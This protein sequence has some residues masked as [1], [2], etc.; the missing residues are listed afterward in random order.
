MNK[1]TKVLSVF[2]LAGAIGT[3]IA[4]AAGCA[5]NHTYG[6][7]L[8][9]KDAN[10]H[11]YHATCGHD[12]WK[13]LE[14]HKD[15]TGDNKCDDCGYELNETP[16][17][18][19]Q[20]IIAKEV[21]GLVV[22]GITAETVVLN[23]ESKTS[24]TIDKSAIKVY[25]AK[26]GEK[27]DEVPDAYLDI[28]LT[29]PAGAAVTEWAN[30]KDDGVYKVNI[31]I[32]NAKMEEG[33][34]AT[35]ADLT[36]A[37]SITIDNAIVPNS[38]TLKSGTT[39][40]VQSVVDSI[41]STWTFEVERKNGDKVAVT[42]TP[43]I[44][45]DTSVVGE[46]KEATVEV[47]VNGV[48]CTGTVLYTITEN[49]EMRV[50][51]YAYNFGF[52]EHVGAYDE[53][54]YLV[55]SK[56]DH[57][58]TYVMI[59]G[60][61]TETGAAAGVAMEANKPRE[62]TD[63]EKYFLNRLTFG[64]GTFT[65]SG[66]VDSNV[67]KKKYLVIKA[68]SAGKLT[69]Y[70]SRNS[71]ADTRGIALWSEEQWNGNINIG[72]SASAA[73]GP[74]D[75][76]GNG[77]S[78]IP[79]ASASNKNTTGKETDPELATFTIPE[80]GVYYL[81]TATNQAAYLYYIQIDNEYN[82]S[83]VENV[84]VEDGEKVVASLKKSHTDDAEGN[85]YVQEFNLG[86]TFSVNSGYS[87]KATTAAKN[88]AKL[89]PDEIIEYSNLTFKIGTTTVVPGTTVL[90]SELIPQTGVVKVTV[91]Y[92][93]ASLQYD[94]KVNS[95]LGVDSITATIN[96]ELNKVVSSADA[97]VLV[98]KSDIIVTAN[99]TNSNVDIEYTAT[100]G[101]GTEITADGVQIGVGD[102]TVTVNATV[103]DKTTS[104]LTKTFT[105]T[106]ALKIVADG[107]GGAWLYQDQ[108]D[109]IGEDNADIA[110]DAVIEDNGSFK[111]EA[112]VAAKSGYN[113]STSDFESKITDSSN[114]PVASDTASGEALTF[115]NA[116][117]FNT[118]AGSGTD[119]IKVTAK[120]AITVYVYLNASDDKHGSN[121]AGT[122][123]YYSVNG[124]P[125]QESEQITSDARKNVMVVKVTLQ[126][127]DVLIISAK[128]GTSST[129]PRIWFY[130]IEAV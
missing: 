59:P 113:M 9:A 101:E 110:K 3:G 99:G 84:A 65:S 76:A 119:Y 78:H 15:T 86:D 25:F 35:V 115:T 17:V 124:T 28:K 103:T 82:D 95:A 75:Y 88:T 69:I 118:K 114:K 70:W 61:K 83:T 41:S 102:W 129:D 130:G 90:N 81:T 120:K 105:A 24:H 22:E 98:K 97:T 31:K 112:L 94:I 46:D 43:K 64:G 10:Q 21:D 39:T 71:S 104:S 91:E 77:S 42:G 106:V 26:N 23:K 53:D 123:A 121:R 60:S 5:H 18:G 20:L 85:P 8:E 14:D 49:A 56:G 122:V 108:Y 40:Q 109:A 72:G 62:S 63:G 89:Y 29:N 96:P 73:D 52:D 128:T 111:A 36:E 32:I 126:A 127:D 68:E 19:S 87:F 7:D 74:Y 50:Q 1:L 30:L 57:T 4:G 54:T 27:A 117:A 58:G 80:A 11:G 37:I 45:I 66:P 13:D 51:S 48:T 12:V 92:G 33:A 107:Q 16:D 47:E 34:Q 67:N 116:V 100:Y 38:L 125:C 55:D 2:L 79:V 6:N 93:D 44:T